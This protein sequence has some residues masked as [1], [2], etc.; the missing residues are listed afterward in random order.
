MFYF[1]AI[2]LRQCKLNN[3]NPLIMKPFEIKAYRK[4]NQLTQEELAEIVKVG[5]GTIRSWEQGK[6]NITKQ[7]EVLMDIFEKSNIVSVDNTDKKQLSEVEKLIEVVN[8][9]RSDISRLIKDNS[10]LIELLHSQIKKEQV[11]HMDAGVADVG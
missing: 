11:A 2:K 7:S 3:V 8:E 9:Q 5:V 10:K 1:S 6:R 4:R